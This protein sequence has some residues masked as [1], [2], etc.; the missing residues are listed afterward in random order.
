MPRSLK[1]AS[2]V[3][4]DAL[5]GAGNAPAFDDRSWGRGKLRPR[6]KYASWGT[7]EALYDKSITYTKTQRLAPSLNDLQPARRETPALFHALCCLSR[8]NPVS[9]APPAENGMRLR[10]TNLPD[11]AK[12]TSKIVRSA[13]SP[14]FCASSTTTL[15]RNSL[16]RRSWSRRRPAAEAASDFLRD[17]GAA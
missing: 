8:W 1:S 11:A 3:I 4:H 14:T 6:R 12:A 5:C 10:S 9:N 13:A 16:S 17:Y 7:P 15:R 2:C